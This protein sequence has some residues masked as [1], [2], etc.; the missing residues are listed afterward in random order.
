MIFRAPE[1]CWWADPHGS[2]GAWAQQCCRRE[3][4]VAALRRGSVWN[5]WFSSFS[6]DLHQ[7]L[8]NIIVG[9]IFHITEFGSICWRLYGFSAEV[10]TRWYMS[11]GFGWCSM[12]T[13]TPHHPTRN[14]DIHPEPGC[15][16][17]FFQ[18]LSLKWL[19]MA[20]HKEKAWGLRNSTSRE[21]A[22]FFDGT[23]DAPLR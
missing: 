17:Q 19:C 20:E 10:A 4:H 11:H 21:G 9:E 18:G 7:G 16:F 2:K 13:F 8:V 15:I 22:P 12:K 23:W 3:R 14:G 6:R 1:E 5:F